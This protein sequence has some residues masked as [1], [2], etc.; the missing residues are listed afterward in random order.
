[1]TR[2]RRGNAEGDEGEGLRRA[3]HQERTA[4]QPDAARDY[5]PSPWEDPARGAQR[6][7][8]GALGTSS[9]RDG[10]PEEVTGPPWE[11]PGWDDSEASRRAPRQGGLT[12]G[13]PSG[14]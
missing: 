5:F 4:R 14:P 6:P 9:G 12:G 8:R 10:G 7:A 11:L 13:H 1:M 3:G 2:H